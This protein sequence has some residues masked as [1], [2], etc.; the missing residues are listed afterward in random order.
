MVRAVERDSRSQTAI[1]GNPAI[2]GNPNH[3]HA[4]RSTMK[5]LLD[6]CD[7]TRT[8]VLTHRARIGGHQ[9]GTT[10]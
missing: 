8:R 2:V 7:Q 5:H 10:P 3:D 9:K 4:I 1:L 6:Y